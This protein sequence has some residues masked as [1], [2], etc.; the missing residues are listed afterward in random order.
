MDRSSASRAGSQN[1]PRGAGR[2]RLHLG[3]ERVASGEKR[4]FHLRVRGQDIGAERHDDLVA[5]FQSVQT[6][7]Q[8]VETARAARRERS[9]PTARRPASAVSA[10]ASQP[11]APTIATRAPSRAAAT[12]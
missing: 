8:P 5:T 9:A 2:V 6:L 4:V 1:R 7:A 3:H 10:K 12:A 11:T